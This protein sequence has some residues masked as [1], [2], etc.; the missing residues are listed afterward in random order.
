MPYEL[1]R[2]EI[3]P[4]PQNQTAFEIDGQERVRWHSGAEYTRP[5]FSPLRG[6][7]GSALTRIGHPGTASHDHHRAIWFAHHN[8]QGVNF[9]TESSAARIRQQ[10]WLDYSDG[11]QEAAMAVSLGW[12]DGHDPA[13]LLTQELIAIVRA[14]DNGETLLELQSTFRPKAESLEFGKTPY[15]FLAVRMAKSISV[16][17]G[18]GKITNSEGRIG[19]K[20]VFGNP[21]RWVDYSGPVPVGKGPARKTVTEGITYFDHPANPQ[22]PAQWHVRDDGWMCASACRNAAITTTRKKP[23]VLRYLL[24]AH[25]GPANAKQI[26]AMAKQFATHGGYQVEPARDANR[27]FRIAKRA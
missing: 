3:V 20:G 1:P 12:Y 27:Q 2:H 13:E 11:A 4:Q 7:S 8:V 23:L 25:G 17:F 26:N 14:A 16:L 5:F 22:H 21:A 10:R 24:W 19:E 9:W 6:P 18:G 15:G